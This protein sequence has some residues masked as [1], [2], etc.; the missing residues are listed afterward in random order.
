MARGSMTFNM[1]SAKKPG[2]TA[3]SSLKASTFRVKNA[4][5]VATNGQTEAIM[6]VTFRIVCSTGMAFTTSQSPRKHTMAN[7]PRTSLKA[8]ASLHSKMADS[9][10]VTSKQEKKT[11]KALWCKPTETNTSAR[12][13]MTRCTVSVFSTTLRTR[14]R[15]KELGRRVSERL[16]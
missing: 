8:R 16:G 4:A 9:T 3:P 6:K 2:R 1:D 10:R 12:G 5:E 15:N 7:L 13:K 11:V 14:R